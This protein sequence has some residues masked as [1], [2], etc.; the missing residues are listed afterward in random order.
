M[1]FLPKGRENLEMSV[2][3]SGYTGCGRHTHSGCP[4]GDRLRDPSCRCLYVVAGEM[5]SV[6]LFGVIEFVR[7]LVEERCGRSMQVLAPRIEISVCEVPS[8]N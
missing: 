6:V 8:L 5:R 7:D 2:C 4:L 3:R 1:P